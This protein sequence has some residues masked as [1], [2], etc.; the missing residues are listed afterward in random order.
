MDGT[1]LLVGTRKGLWIGR[2]DAERRE[3][4][5]TGPHFDMEEVYSCMVD[6]RGS[7][8][9][10]LVGSSSSWVGPQVQRS[11]DLG[12]TWAK[13]ADGAIRFPDDTGT[14]LER[15]WQLTPGVGR[16]RGLRR[17]RAGRRVPLRRRRRDVRARTRALGPP[18]PAAVGAGFGG[19]AFHTILP[20]PTD[21]S[22]VTCRALHRR[23]LPDRRRR[24]SWA[25]R[26]QGIRA[27][28][29]PEGQQYP[30][31]G[32]C[33]HKVARHP[34]TPQ[35]MFLQNH[36][37]VYRSDDEGGSWT[38]IADGLPADFGFPIVVHPH[39][40]E[41]V[42]VFPLNGAGRALPAGGP[43]AGL[44][45]PRRR[46]AAGSHWGRGCPTRSSSASCATRC[47]PTTTSAAGST[48]ER[49]TA[50]SGP[51]PTGAR[52]GPRPSA[53]CPT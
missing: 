48:S 42:F 49:A 52:P 15:V 22:S 27:E 47:A 33:V 44:A 25:P 17:H 32:Q 40:P 9:R 6:T 13:S 10:L 35:R 28:F 45:L 1:I 51:R 23:G 12:R 3:W 4:E 5:F 30:E 11:D 39:E 21:A 20:H 38:S 14:S 53:T 43:R 31:F 18:A 19:Q 24:L 7:N 50:R 46:R 8:P 29:L 16:R 36:G 2:S 41:T 34:S 26:N 37:G